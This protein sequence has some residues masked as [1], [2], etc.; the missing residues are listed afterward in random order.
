MIIRIGMENGIEGR[1]LAWALDHPGCFAYGKNAGEA[2][3][4]LP[5]AVLAYTDWIDQHTA[6]SWLKGLGDFDIRLVEAFECYT[7]DEDFEPVESGYEVNAWFRNDWKPLTRLE[8]Q[9]GLLMLDWCRADLLTLVKPLTDV[10][11][12][13]DPRHNQWTIRRILDHIAGAE[14]WYLDR[15]DQA[16]IA[17]KDL[18]EDYFPRLEATRRLLEQR[19]KEW[20]GVTLVAGKVGELWSPRKILRRT[21]WH[22]RD[23]IDHIRQLLAEMGYESQ[24]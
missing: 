12:D 20:E 23:H 8:V 10:Q 24:K 1:S 17:R 7:I 11:L 18:P 15:L 5:R 6:D 3:A 13:A 14:W 2:L 22:S 9:R 16:G 21:L 19:F 4:N